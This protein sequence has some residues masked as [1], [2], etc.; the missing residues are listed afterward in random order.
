MEDFV[1]P[2]LVLLGGFVAMQMSLRNPLC[3]AGCGVRME[4]YTPPERM[5]LAV[6]AKLAVFALLGSPPRPVNASHVRCPRCSETLT[7]REAFA[8]TGAGYAL[9]L[10]GIVVGL[11]WL[12]MVSLT[13]LN[14]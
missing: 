4:D 8:G 9:G 2:A 13:A 10:L 7:K 6:A 5:A 12:A 14:S 11:V 3:R 1:M